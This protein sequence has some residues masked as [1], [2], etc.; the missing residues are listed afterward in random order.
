MTF[1]DEATWRGKVYS[2]GWVSG[3]G[4][5]PVIEPATGNELGRT[6]IAGPADVAAA[7]ARAAAAQ[8][9]WAA[10]PHTQRAAILRKAAEIW[11]ANAAEI[12]GWSI[13]EGGKIPPAAQFETHVATEEI[14]EAATL[15]NRATG[16][17][18]PSEQPRLS[19]V[20]R[21]PA[22]VVGV[23][24]PFNFPQILAIRSVAPALALGNAVVLKPDPRTA[25]CGGVVLARVFEEA[26]LPDGLL[27]VLPGGV[28]A[29]EALIT[30]PA[31]RVISFTGSTAAGRRVGELAA[32]HLKRVHLELGGNSALVVLDDAD[33]DL[34]ASAGA[35]GS[36]LHQG[37][38]CMTTG[39]HL[40]ARRHLRRVR[41]PSGRQGRAPAGG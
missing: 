25:V 39:R 2:G 30:E 27:H 29:G 36:F 6:G 16:E 34:A 17:I 32:R 7:V 28:D 40:V 11:L 4:E 23:I 19:F 33:L 10:T 41:G 8:P 22:G 31:V 14:F 37:Q 26:G 38:I 15:P 12:E 20:E 24:A 21:I 18:I 13:R 35:W 9:A 3:Q 5:A 1:L